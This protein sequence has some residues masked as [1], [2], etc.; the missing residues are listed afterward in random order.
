MSHVE[1]RRPVVSAQLLARLGAERGLPVEDCLRDTGIDPAELSDPATE[2]TIEQELQL[3]RNLLRGLGPVPGLGLDAGMR[4]HLS[5]YGIWGFA[6]LSS[7]TFRSAAEIAV[8]YLDLSY[9]FA[10]YR[11]ENVGKDLLIILD[12]SNVPEDVRQFL[13]ERDFTA[14][15]NAA[16]EMRPG[17]FPGRSAQFRFPRPDYAWRFDKICG[18]RPSFDAPMNAIL[19]SAKDLDAPLPQANPM[20]ARMCEEQCR[21]LLARRRV[22]SG[23]AGQIRDRLLRNPGEMP[24]LET[25]AEELHMASR[26]LRRRLDEEGTTFR[27]LVD[28][29]RQTLAEEL[30]MSAHM[31]LAEIAA[32]L[33]YT[34]PAAFISAFKR[35]KG[36]S[37]TAYR[38]QRQRG[39][40]SEAE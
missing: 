23:L 35:W 27:A 4:Y 39:A 11:L 37:P 40:V 20:M 5:A 28:E 6:L 9:A 32:R 19:L 38:Q 12:D 31:K 13:V 22:R 33:G 7:P 21:Q 34:E 10:R 36:M 18:V 3:I 2:I 24:S 17:G 29:V 25:V 14:W 15:A 30:L 26:S 8:R 16:W 1:V